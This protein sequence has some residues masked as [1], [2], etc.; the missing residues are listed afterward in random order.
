V[1]N[2]Q[3]I[4]HPSPNKDIKLFFGVGPLLGFDRSVMDKN[5]EQ[6]QVDTLL[7]QNKLS[8]NGKGWTVGLSGII[9]VEFFCFKKY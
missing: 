2:S 1:I 8:K 7:I 9:G 6:S 3:Y 5:D 4:Y